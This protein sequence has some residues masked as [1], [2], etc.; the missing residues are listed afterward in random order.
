MLKLAAQEHQGRLGVTVGVED[1]PSL[2][3]SANVF[4]MAVFAACKLADHSRV[5]WFVSMAPYSITRLQ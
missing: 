5:G 2:Q 1:P 3:H 4:H